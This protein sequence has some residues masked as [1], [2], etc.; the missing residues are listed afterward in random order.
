M[1]WQLLHEANQQWL[2]KVSLPTRPLPR[3]FV[4]ST[5]RSC[6]PFLG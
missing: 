3:P 4:R 2:Q 6:T 1:S 5:R